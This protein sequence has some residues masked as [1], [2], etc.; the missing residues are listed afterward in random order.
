MPKVSVIVPVYNTEKYLSRCINSILAQSFDDYEM[1]LVDDG[2][3]DNSGLF[4]DEYV[5]RDPR[6]RVIHKENGGVSSARNVGIK[7]AVG[8]YIMFCDS[9]DYVDPDWCRVLYDTIG[10]NPNAFIV[11]DVL[12]IPQT[13]MAGLQRNEECRSKEISYCQLYKLGI[14]A[15]T[16]N[17]IYSANVIKRNNLLFDEKCS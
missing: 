8:E 12:H 4:L 9:D 1:I 17:K 16:F 6:I 10:K 5:N 15:Y 2:S 14:S 13:G 7:K 11:S 3:T